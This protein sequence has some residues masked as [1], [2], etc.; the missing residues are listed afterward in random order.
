MQHTI[1]TVRNILNCE[2][3]YFTFK[4]NRN[5]LANTESVSS[6]TG[7]AISKGPYEITTMRLF[8]VVLIKR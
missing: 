2:T 4:K 7:I 8:Q 3:C 5:S 6:H 1:S